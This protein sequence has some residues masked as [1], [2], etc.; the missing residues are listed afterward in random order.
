MDN[1]E[2]LDKN[3]LEEKEEENRKKK[4]MAA[5]A[6]RKCKMIYNI[7]HGGERRVAEKKSDFFW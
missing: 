1:K 5:I 6:R 3:E 2:Y 4:Q 7:R